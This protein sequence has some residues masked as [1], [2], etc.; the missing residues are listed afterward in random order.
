MS[1]STVLRSLA[2]ATAAALTATPALPQA[3]GLA[4]SYLAAR[5]A[6]YDNDF[7][8]ASDYYVRA[9]VRDPANPV[10]M[11]NA[12]VSLVAVGRV[13][14]AVPIGRQMLSRDISSQ[15]A[16]LVLAADRVKRDDFE[17]L[18]EELDAGLTIGPLVDSLLRAWSQVGS[19]RMTEALAEFDRIAE[20]NGIAAFGAYHKAL[21]LGSVGDFE[22]AVEVFDS[23]AAA[24]LQRSRRALLVE[25]RML[26]QLDRND[27]AAALINEAFGANPDPG[28]KAVL[29]QISA[30]ETLEFDQITDAGDGAA[31]VFYTVATAL[32]GEAN[33]G[34]TLGYVRIA[35]Y[36]KPGDS[37]M[38]L[39]SAALLERLEQYELATDIYD[40]VPRGAPE[41]Y[42][43]EIG[44]AESLRALGREDAAVE[45]LKQLAESHGDIAVVHQTLGDMLRRT[46]RY[47]ES[48]EAYDNAIAL[49]D[50]PG[51]RDW[52]VFF[53]RGITHERMGEWPAADTDFRTALEL[54]PEQ[55]QVLNYLGYSMVELNLDLDEALDL[56]ERAVA[57]RPDDGYI[58]DSLGWVLYRLGRY[59]EA[60]VHM[61]RAVELSP[62]DPIINDH[63]GDVLWAV[64]RKLEARFQWSRALSFDPEEKD[65]DRIRRKLEVG[66]DV[67][68]E[69][70]GSEPLAVA[71]DEG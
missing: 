15:A 61:E 64:D 19:G 68:L 12:I 48:S 30:G 52:G 24:Q 45:V 62:V 42:D 31:E 60:V 47:Q 9:L 1:P 41:F 36:L 8:A 14:R 23:G 50:E 56:I 6:S 34:Y 3:D 69:E 39:L 21:A 67:V 57:A 65:A 13:E 44:R 17:G 49:L 7:Q 5:A 10:L 11:E 38:I 26:S 54:N 37:D 27:D 58:T 33:D 59:E 51:P 28:V 2:F 46:E 43:A 4:G 40:Q 63:L 70:E 20:Q 66:L 32:S 18:L 16:A 25:V 22:G 53:T 71:N 35:D 55:P 29:T